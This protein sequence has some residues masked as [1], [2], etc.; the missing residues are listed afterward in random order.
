MRRDA[1]CIKAAATVLAAAL[2]LATWLLASP[3]GS[4]PDD[5]Y[6]LSSIWYA[7]GFHPE[8]CIDATPAG[9]SRTELVLVPEALNAVTCMA[10]RST[11]PADCLYT[12]L[13]LPENQLW[14]TE[15]GNVR[16]ERAG[17][18]Y[19]AMHLFV[20][21]DY[22]RS[23][24]LIR[25]SNAVLALIALSLTL[26]VAPPNVRA[27]V[28][29][30]WLVTAIPLGLF[31]LTS[32]NSSA[33]GFVGLGLVW[34]NALTLIHSTSRRTR[35]SAAMLIAV[36]AIMALG[37][38]TEA[39]GHLSFSTLALALLALER[40]WTS[41]SGSRWHSL[42]ATTRRLTQAVAAVVLLLLGTALFR[43]APLDY[44]QDSLSAP[45]EGYERLV[46]GGRG[47]PLI[48][49]FTETPLLWTGAFGD[50]FGLGWLDTAMPMIVYVFVL[51]TFMTLL[52]LGLQGARWER[53]AAVVTMVVA[54]FVL[55]IYTLLSVGAP[56]GETFQPRH[57]LPTT[58][59][60][61]GIGLVG[62][63]GRPRPRLGPGGVVGL[64]AV[65][66][67]A[68]AVALHTNIRRYVTGLR[69]DV[70]LD[71]NRDVAW[72]W[73]HGPSPMVTWVVG[74]LAF[75]ALAVLVLNLMR[76]PSDSLR[77]GRQSS[78]SR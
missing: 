34:A 69:L 73:A 38:R 74:S 28:A 23:F 12:A 3:P 13:S 68:H 20:S 53:I 63:H 45:R 60:L 25:I 8:R 29:V 10:F 7:R 2:V 59:L 39:I 22:P 44:L 70:Y 26:L 49:L 54:M 71:L 9:S 46:M 51:A 40:P 11:E 6:H 19:R 57:Y 42:P 16:Q 77:D 36:G 37:A 52:G 67:V 62:S 35:I 18:Y 65:I 14:M 50:R 55:P 31:L 27:S 78:P 76:D 64:A 15:G 75:G 43:L 21:D 72:W 4:S 24:M 33:W 41:H 17:L 5:G 56:V 48:T 1:G 47:Q 32:L 58:M 30:T 61:I 66:T